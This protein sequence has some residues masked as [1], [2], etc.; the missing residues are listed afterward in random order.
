MQD[1]KTVESEA[2]S[3][4]VESQTNETSGKNNVEKPHVLNEKRPHSFA[5]G[6]IGL[7]A[8]IL[9]MAAVSA[10]VAL[11]VFTY[12]QKSGAG[13]I[14]DKF[15]TINFDA[16]VRQ[17]IIALSDKVRSGIIKPTEMP[18]ISKKF[19]LALLD[20][21]NAYAKDGKIVLKNDAVIAAPE[22]VLDVTDKIR[23]EL[24]KEGVMDLPKDKPQQE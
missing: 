23:D 7:M 8:D 13:S 9:V 10:A 4:V 12:L 6:L 20:K 3:A 19:T 16:L 1:N 5:Q 24:V 15:I 14:D 18:E 11:M 21:M 22:T 2:S 17:E